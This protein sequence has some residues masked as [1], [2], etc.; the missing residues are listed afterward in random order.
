M[1]TSP[2]QPRSHG[3]WADGAPLSGGQLRS[4]TP[5]GAELVYDAD[6]RRP[7][8]GRP[9]QRASRVMQFEGLRGMSTRGAVYAR[10]SAALATIVVVSAVIHALLAP[11]RWQSAGR[12]ML[13]SAALMILTAVAGT[14]VYTNQRNEII[15]QVRHFVFGLALFPGLGFAVLMR[16]SSDFFSGPTAQGD[17]FASML[18]NALPILYFITVLIPPL[19]FIKTIA[20]LRN[21]HR[22]N[23]DNEEYM[24]LYTRQDE[25]A[26]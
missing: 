21:L 16:A 15:E 26:R 14:M 11:T 3:S 22:S 7:N 18:G 2:M 1:N 20:G 4:E 17:A 12:W 19:V 25:L 5:F 9:P 8:L 10:Y 6:R 24:R 23:L 13:L